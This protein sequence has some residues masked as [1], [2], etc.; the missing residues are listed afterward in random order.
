MLKQSAHRR[1]QCRHQ[2]VEAGVLDR[3]PPENTRGCHVDKQIVDKKTFAF[4]ALGKS[5][6]VLEKADVRLALAGFM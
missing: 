4:F 5:L 6:R 3:V 2:L 1:A